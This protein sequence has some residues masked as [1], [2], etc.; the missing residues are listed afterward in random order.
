MKSSIG[1]NEITMI[2]LLKNVLG[3]SNKI[4]NDVRVFLSSNRWNIRSL[5]TLQNYF[6]IRVNNLMLLLW[7]LLICY[8]LRNQNSPSSFL[9]VG[10]GVVMVTGAELDLIWCEVS[11]ILSIYYLDCGPFCMQSIFFWVIC[12]RILFAAK[13]KKRKKECVGGG[14]V[15]L[16]CPQC[17]FLGFLI[18]ML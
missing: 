9:G 1:N 5:I 17:W 10:I 4:P 15:C 6:V 14:W 16:P 3:Y 12:S 7:V 2:R 11:Y 13:K 18:N 8:F